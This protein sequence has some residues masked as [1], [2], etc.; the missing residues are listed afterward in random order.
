MVAKGHDFPDVTLGVV[1]DADSTLNFPDF[2]AEERTFALVAQLGGRSG[3]GGT[4][5][6][7]LVQ[8]RS[9]ETRA[10]R[11]AAKHDSEG[12]VKEELER[13]EAFGYPPFGHMVKIQTASE[14]LA[15]AQAAAD[16]LAKAIELSDARVMGP[17]N[18]FKR[19]GLER[20]Q[21]EVKTYDR[22]AA[23]TSVREAVELVSGGA[24]G[25]NVKFAVDVDPQ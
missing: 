17:T 11:F 9:P 25:R 3:R 16:H 24:A 5:G 23:V 14:D 18:L 20:Y 19:K 22:D 1:I 10:L 8:T 6:R 12:F 7:V 2:R 15:R 13:R 4:E 21:L